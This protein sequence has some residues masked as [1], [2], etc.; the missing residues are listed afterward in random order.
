MGTLS[1]KHKLRLRLLAMLLAEM[2]VLSHTRD[3]A[4]QC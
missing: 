1:K 3:D 2:L 4:E